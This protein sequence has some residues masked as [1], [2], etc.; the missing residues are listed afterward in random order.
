MSGQ[1]KKQVVDCEDLKGIPIVDF[2]FGDKLRIDEE[3][4]LSIGTYLMNSW[5]KGIQRKK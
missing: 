1:K 5:I 3:K 2:V 4:P